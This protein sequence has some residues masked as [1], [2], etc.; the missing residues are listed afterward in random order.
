MARARGPRTLASLCGAALVACA[1]AGLARADD[2]ATSN[3]AA[4]DAPGEASE[5][6]PD[7]AH[8]V[9]D[10]ETADDGHA[11]VDEQTAD[12]GAAVVDDLPAALPALDPELEA[13][14]AS[15]SEGLANAFGGAAL[16]AS[17][18]IRLEIDESRDL[19]RDEDLQAGVTLTGR[20]GAEIP[21]GPHR[22]RVVVGDGR[23]FGRDDGNLT[24]PFVATD[25]LAFL[26]EVSLA[27]DLPLLGLPT[28]VEV[29][30]REVVVADGRLV[31]RAPFDPRGRTLDGALLSAHTTWVSARAGAFY[32]G[33]YVPTT[34]DGPS[35]LALVDVRTT[36]AFH[37]VTGYALALRDGRFADGARPL[38]APT[39][40]G[41]AIGRVFF[42]MAR[43][44]ADVQA[45][46]EDGSTQTASAYAGHVELGLEAA[47][48]ITLL[49]V[50]GAPVVG[51]DVE[52]TGGVSERGRAFLL[53]APD[54]HDTLGNL[55]LVDMDNV[56]SAR[57]YVGLQAMQGARALVS[58]RVLA[59]TDPTGAIHDPR[60]RQIVA[61][62]DTRTDRVLFTELDASLSLDVGHGL[63]FVGEYGIAFP[64]PARGGE[65]PVQRLLVSLAFDSERSAPLETS[66]LTAVLP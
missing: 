4:P 14:L 49:S 25:V 24:H 19:A 64:G 22:A 61:P 5:G 43:A 55:D 36:G 27:V 45:T 44:G 33:P 30:R 38:T 37:D 10:D 12:D 6:P 20:V 39:L 35:A 59:M 48:E 8:A 58:A 26:Y 66:A 21:L 9:V 57:A 3:D 41:R 47:P 52:T 40:G 11:V 13:L 51:V 1:C 29:G 2:G 18:R 62:S 31:G 53:P 54:V 34:N 56:S 28:V 60:G 15:S 50:K 17:G 46:L 7:D 16:V 23:R 42:L 63:F 32:L 65:V